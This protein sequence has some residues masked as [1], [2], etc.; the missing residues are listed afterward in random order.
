MQDDLDAAWSLYQDVVAPTPAEPGFVVASCLAIWVVA[1]IADWA[2]FRLW[3][4]FEA[5]LPAGTLFLF[6]ALLGETAGRGWAVAAVRRRAARLPAPAPHGPPGRQQPL[7]RRPARR[8]EPLAPRRRRRARRAWPSSAGSVLGP[9]VPGA[10]SPGVLDSASIGGDDSRVTVSPLVD[11]RS[12][13][14][15]QAAVEVFPVRVAGARRTG[16]SPRSRSSTGASG[17]PAAAS[18]RPTASSPSRSTASRATARSSSRRSPSRPWPRSGCPSAY[19]PRALDIEG[20]EVRYDEESATLI[21][22][23]DVD[24]QRRPHLPGDVAL[25]AHHPGGPHGHRRRD[26]RRHPRRATSACPRTSARGCAQLAARD[27]SRARPRPA[28]QARALQDHLRTLRPTRSRCSRA[29]ARTRWRTSSSRTRSATASSSP[30]RS[31]RWPARSGSPRAS[32][33]GFTPGELDP[34]LEDTYIVRGEYA[35]AWPEVYIA[36]RGLGA[37]RAHA[38]AAASRTPSPTP[39][40]RSSRPRPANGGGVDDRAHHRPRPSRSPTH[41]E[42]PAGRPATP[43]RTSWPATRTAATDDGGARS[44]TGALRACDRSSRVAPDRAGPGAR[45]RCAVPAR[46]WCV[47]RR[48]RR[49]RADDAA[50]AGRPGL[51]R[52]R[53]GRRHRRLRGAGQRHLRRAGP[54]PRRGRP[55]GGRRRRSRSPLAWRW[56][57]TRPTA[58]TP[59]TPPSAWEAADAIGE[60]AQ[61]AGVALERLRRVVRPALAAAVVAAGAGRPPA[62]HHAHAARRPRG[63]ARAASAPTTGAEARASGGAT[64]RRRGGSGRACGRARRRWRP[65]SR[66]PC[67]ERVTCSRPAL[68]SLRRLRSK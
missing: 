2:A 43:T 39:G 3:V 29:T 44:G 15:E 12:R 25:A 67:S 50:R 10:G 33:S 51:D 30:A 28:D 23:N 55:R 35:H 65:G 41:A 53:G 59:T 56:A 68:P 34:D 49:Q 42:R 62:A 22:D 54:P 37:L 20:A 9:A 36:G 17:R 26:P 19:E 48:R 61:A 38:R 63:R 58:P 31:R 27:R 5:T 6:T 64:R 66:W 45:V 1:Y 60:A 52:G 7:G 14:V 4:P 46:R 13:L 16:G 32:R 57:S 11:I 8:R 24:H 47:R 40:C 21:V 18:A